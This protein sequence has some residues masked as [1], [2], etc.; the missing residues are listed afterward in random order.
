RGRQETQRTMAEQP[1]QPIDANMVIPE[2][3]QVLADLA[4]QK[5]GLRADPVIGT[6][7][8]DLEQAR[9]CIDGVA[10]LA[11]VVDSKLDP[12]DQREMRTLVTNLRMNFV[13]QQEMAS[14]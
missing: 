10:A 12:A 14:Q 6:T 3:I 7:Q 9:L 8:R 13:Q 1:G 4:W 11:G 5:L 2:L